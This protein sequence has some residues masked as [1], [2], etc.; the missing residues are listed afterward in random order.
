VIKNVDRGLGAPTFPPRPLQHLCQ[1]LI[2][3]ISQ[4]WRA[5]GPKTTA[6]TGQWSRL[7][8]QSV[9]AAASQAAQWRTI[10]RLSALQSCA[11]E[12]RNEPALRAA[13]DG[14]ETDGPDY[15]IAS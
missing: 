15:F 9:R 2:Q 6:K 3:E 14:R 11:T 12:R 5:S 13:G 1:S 4:P 7:M 10:D 8:P